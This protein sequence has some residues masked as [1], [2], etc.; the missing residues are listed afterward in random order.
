MRVNSMKV[1]TPGAEHEGDPDGGQ[2]REHGRPGQ[3][4]LLADRRHIGFERA[5]ET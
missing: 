3:V 2:H 4:D 5:H 1:V